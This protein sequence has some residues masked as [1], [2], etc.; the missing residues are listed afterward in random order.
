MG[1]TTNAV[2]NH[3]PLWLTAGIMKLDAWL[4][5]SGLSAE[6]F[7]R[8]LGVSGQAVR[9]WCSGERAPNAE[10]V[11]TISAATDGLVTAQDIHETRLVRLRAAR[12]APLGA[13][14]QG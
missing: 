2:D 10:M 14:A 11:E 13:A 8:Q 12:P 9:R 7:G 3:P 1:A 5:Q 4:S 6:A